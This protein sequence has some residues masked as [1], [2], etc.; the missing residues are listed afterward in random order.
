MSPQLDCVDLRGLRDARDRFSDA[1]CHR[2]RCS[3]VASNFSMK[4]GS[5]TLVPLDALSILSMQ[6][7]CL[8]WSS[9][10]PDDNGSHFLNSAPPIS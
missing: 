1:L 10:A 9:I 3:S 2:D 6:C 5:D 4:S 7:V 8:L